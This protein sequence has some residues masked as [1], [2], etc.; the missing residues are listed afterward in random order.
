MSLVNLAHGLYLAYLARCLHVWVDFGRSSWY[1]GFASTDRVSLYLVFD[2]PRGRVDY[3]VVFVGRCEALI[4]TCC[5]ISLLQ[6]R[7]LIVLIVKWF[8]VT[9]SFFINWFVE[10][11]LLQD[12]GALFQFVDFLL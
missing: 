10:S 9:A 12:D 1:N 8:N 4:T 2:W 11:F 5:L 7:F 6:D 3:N